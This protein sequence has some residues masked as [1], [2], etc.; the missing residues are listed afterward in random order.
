M[1]YF[2]IP[3]LLFITFL[4]TSAFLALGLSGSSFSTFL[5][6]NFSYLRPYLLFNGSYES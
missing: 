4:F 1:Y 2:I 6:K 3:A 5:D